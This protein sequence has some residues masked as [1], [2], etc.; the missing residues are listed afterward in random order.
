[1]KKFLTYF[2]LIC[3][4]SAVAFSC[5]AVPEDP[6]H[7]D[8]VVAAPEVG[9]S[10]A[11]VKDSSS[12]VTIRPAGPA[13]YYAYLIDED[14]EV[15]E[16]DPAKLY[17]QAYSAFDGGLVKYDTD[18]V[19]VLNLNGLLPNT[20]YVVY[21]VAGS[22]TGVVGEVSAET[23]KTS[24]AVAPTLLVD[25]CEFQDNMVALV[26]DEPVN[27]V[28]GKKITAVAY[29][30]RYRGAAD[31]PL[32]ADC[33]GKVLQNKNGV[34][35]VQFA[36]VAIP[37]TWYLV[38][39]EA[40]TFTDY[41]NNP[42]AALASS[43]KY[44]DTGAVA[45]VDGVYGRIKAATIELEAPE[46]SVITDYTE[47]FS[48]ITATEIDAVAKNAVTV[49]VEH[50]E[51]GKTITTESVLSGAPYYGAADDT[52]FVVRLAEEP[53]AGD[54]IT[55]TVAAKAI[56][57]IYG[58]TSEEIVIGPFL[59]SYGYKIE[60]IFGEYQ[61]DGT[62]IYG[63][64]YDEDPWT[65][66]LE[67]SDSL[68]AGNVMITEYYG[69]PCKIYADF[70]C[71]LGLLEF[72]IDQE[73]LDM[74]LGGGGAY[75]FVYYTASYFTTFKGGEDNLILSM[76]ELGKFTD[77]NDYPGYV[78]EA[79]KIPEGGLEELDPDNDYAGYDYNLFQPVFTKVVAAPGS[80]PAKAS[81]GVSP[82]IRHTLRNF[83]DKKRK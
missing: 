42:A 3:C 21:A 5:T 2:A 69:F 45:G 1:M 23:F 52:T 17:S 18:S 65:F 25:D 27:L 54:M 43:W 16:I 10:I 75:L 48:V 50:K 67:A 39:Y 80:A 12:V 47:Y 13:A 40:G 61:N 8:E 15:E 20:Q 31:A 82:K 41:A 30:G 76:T 70:D 4:I 59:Y 53:A 24:D 83:E 74:A 51:G 19:T 71:D 63:A 44:D 37:G 6:S 72:P 49:S 56:T 78:Y 35:F 29:A 36:D 22:T 9:I 26:F 11:S 60:D 58:S 73:D 57:D 34:V 66:V 55:V 81:L 64:T 14:A 28:E 33:E 77:G 32:K 62:S 68:E 38:N 46:V 7:V 79:Y